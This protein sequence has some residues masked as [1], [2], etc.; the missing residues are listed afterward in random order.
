VR[1]KD[2]CRGKERENGRVETGRKRKQC[3]M[4]QKKG[5]G[6]GRK[7]RVKNEKRRR[8]IQTLAEWLEKWRCL[9]DGN[10]EG[11]G[12][13]WR[14]ITDHEDFELIT[15]SLTGSTLVQQITDCLMR[16][17][18]KRDGFFFVSF[19]E[20]NKIKTANNDF[21]N[22]GFQRFMVPYLEKTK[23][24]FDA[25]EETFRAALVDLQYTVEEEDEI[26]DE[27][28]LEETEDEDILDA[29]AAA[30]VCLQWWILIAEFNLEKGHAGD[31]LKCMGNEFKNPK[32]R[33]VKSVK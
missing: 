3:V 33:A 28:I 31:L 16:G 13:G 5:V 24:Y 19:T 26:A 12:W 2:D 30:S 25:R 21:E 8:R 29:V 14:Y 18:T 23:P 32:F 27:G 6:G 22:A 4:K 20:V 17:F 10:D 1:R 15:H 9:N 7:K 11:V